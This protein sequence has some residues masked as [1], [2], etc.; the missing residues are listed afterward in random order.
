MILSCDYL[1]TSA[2]PQ[3]THSPLLENLDVSAPPEVL[4]AIIHALTPLPAE[5]TSTLVL[6]SL[7]ISFV[8]FRDR[9]TGE[10]ETHTLR[11]GREIGSL[12]ARALH[13]RLDSGCPSLRELVI[14]S[15][16]AEECCFHAFADV[17]RVSYCDCAELDDDDDDDS[18][19]D[20]GSAT[21]NSTSEFETDEDVSSG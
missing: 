16:M 15:C 20:D 13:S 4:K 1:S 9:D 11:T 10:E 2:L 21:D 8:D 3:I 17:V 5:I 6:E 7:S 18:D 12:L 19:S 14:D